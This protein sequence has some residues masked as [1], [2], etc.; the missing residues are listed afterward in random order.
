M[1]ITKKPFEAYVGDEPYIFVS[2]AHR[3]ADRVYPIL[4]RLHDMGY[5]I[6]YDEGIDPGNEWLSDIADALFQC[7][8]FVVMISENAVRS[9]NVKKEVFS[10]VR[11]ADI[12][13]LPIFIEETSLPR[14][15][16]VNIS[17]YQGIMH[18]LMHQENFITLIQRAFSTELLGEAVV[19]QTLPHHKVINKDSRVPIRLSGD[20]F[21]DEAV[22]RKPAAVKE[23]PTV[24]ADIIRAEDWE[25]R[26]PEALAVVYHTDN[27]SASTLQR[28]MSIGYVRAER[29]L[30]QLATLEIIS[31]TAIARTILMDRESAE[32]LVAYALRQA[33]RSEEWVFA[34]AVEYLY[35]DGIA[36][37]SYL[38]RKLK[39]GF[40]MAARILD[41]LERL[42]IISGAD[43]GALMTGRN[44]LVDK[45]QALAL[46][47]SIRE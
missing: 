42:G 40:S 11:K 46:I 20:S 37:A 9:I 17:I 10:V 6:W 47:Q 7:S 41:E 13:F 29:L 8:Q 26:L 39:V 18:H 1:D 43:A 32:A 21:E 23:M 2:Y 25:P 16:D 31:N 5:R 24:S 33:V 22:L 45:E 12:P 27:V 36:S 4:Q 14:D 28:E 19:K 15:W 30:E 35:S 3:D 44:L 38:K 34:Q